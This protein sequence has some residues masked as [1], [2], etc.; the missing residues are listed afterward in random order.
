MREYYDRWPQFS[1]SLSWKN[2]LKESLRRTLIH[3]ADRHCLR[4]GVQD[5]LVISATVQ[6]RIAREGISS[7]VLHPPP[8]VR[9]YRC[10]GYGDYIF[11]VS[12]L[13]PLKR[14]DL[15]LTALAEHPA[16]G[17]RAVIAGEGEDRDRLLELRRRLGLDRRVEFVGR[18]T[19]AQ[20]LDHLA[21]CRAVAFVPLDE[22]YGF[23]TVEAFASRK[24][25]IT[26]VDSGGPTE[27]VE[28]GTNGLVCAPK[29]SAIAEA[30]RRC[31]D[32]P[33]AAERMG[34]AGAARAARL[35][36]AATVARLLSGPPQPTV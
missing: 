25:V 26:C 6:A 24:A 16:R 22:D 11:A 9:S 1:A 36:W 8:P 35:T 4:R 28:D 21:L 20:V 30:L 12:R 23:V 29:P 31:M 27:L 5:R 14:F 3:Q 34:G 17:I 15:F 2:R 7:E 32:D 33:V 10:D 13:T 18:L 19:D